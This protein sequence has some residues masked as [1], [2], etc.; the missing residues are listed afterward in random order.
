MLFGF[1][2]SGSILAVANPSV[3]LQKQSHSPM[4]YNSV[5]SKITTVYNPLHL[6]KDL[7]FMHQTKDKV[8]IQSHNLPFIS[9]LC[10]FVL[11]IAQA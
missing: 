8:A 4:F 9:V 3:K 1:L 10:A 5:S 7:R 6:L 11:G 2:L